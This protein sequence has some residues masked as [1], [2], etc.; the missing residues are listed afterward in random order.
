MCGGPQKSQPMAQRPA[1]VVLPADFFLGSKL[2]SFLS[3]ATLSTISEIYKNDDNSTTSNLL[4]VALPT[5]H[6]GRGEAPTLRL[7]T[8]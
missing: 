1:W 3:R 5:T 8:K 4:R 7:L 6:D 2:V